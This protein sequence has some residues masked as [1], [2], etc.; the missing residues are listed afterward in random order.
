MLTGATLAPPPD[1]RVTG[2]AL[3]AGSLVNRGTG[4]GVGEAPQ[5][6]R[7]AVPSTVASLF[8]AAE[9]VPAGAVE[10]G[11]RIRQQAADG[12]GTGVYDVAV[13]PDPQGRT[14]S[15]EACPLDLAAVQRLLDERPELTLDGGRP[16]AETLA[17]R[18]AG[19]WCSDEVVLYVGRAGPRR[20]IRVSPL[21]DRVQE[22]YDTQPARAARTPEDGR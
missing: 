19:F 11:E 10:W 17:R 22:Y 13:T 20:R 16:D 3:L 18:L 15:E 7:R 21:S 12:A 9:A 1:P 5:R 6:Y 2:A 14:D 8:T 4:G